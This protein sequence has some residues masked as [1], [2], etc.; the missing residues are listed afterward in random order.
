MKI[1][2]VSQRTI[3]IGIQFRLTPGR[4]VELTPENLQN[5]DIL[6]D[7]EVMRKRGFIITTETVKVELNKVDGKVVATVQETPVA[8]NVPEVVA[9]EVVVTPEVVAEVVAEEVVVT[10]EVVAEVVAEE[11]VEAVPAVKAPAAKKPAAKK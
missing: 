7:I 4:E 2:N 6:K 5:K 8:V 11:V 3:Y 9:E 1:K 10:P